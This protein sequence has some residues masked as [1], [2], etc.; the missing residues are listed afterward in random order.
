MRQRAL[1]AFADFP[2]VRVTRSEH[3]SVQRLDREGL[4][5]RASSASYL[6]TAGPAAERLRA[7]LNA[8]FDR[9][10][11]EGYVELAIVTYVLVA[12]W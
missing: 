7:D 5:G 6:P 9:F 8:L 12:D 4:L 10:E 1:T 2:D 11:R 3:S